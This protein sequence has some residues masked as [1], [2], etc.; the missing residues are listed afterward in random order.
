MSSSLDGVLGLSLTNGAVVTTINNSSGTTLFSSTSGDINITAATGF[1][2]NLS[3]TAVTGPMSLNGTVGTA[4]QVPV[5]QGPGLPVI[6]GVGGGTVTSVGLAMPSIFTVSNSPVVGAGTLT[7]ALNTQADNLVF[8]GPITGGP[9]APTFRALDSSDITTAMLTPPAIGTTTPA[10][11]KFTTLTVTGGI[12][13]PVE[14]VNVVFAGPASG[15]AAAPTFRAL[16]ATDINTP[17]ATS[18]MTPPSI[19]GTTPNAAIFTDAALTTGSV[20]SAPVAA[21]D[22]ANKAYVDLYIQGLTS[23]TTVKAATTTN[24]TLTG[25]QVIDTVPVVAGDIVLV[26]DQGSPAANGVYTVVAG[27]WT[28]APE[29]DVWS[30]FHGAFV[31]VETIAGASNSATGWVCTAPL[32][33]TIDV[34]P[35]PFQQFS[36]AGTY[37]AGTG[38]TLT[39]S[40]FSAN[41]TNYPLAVSANSTLAALLTAN[42][43][44]DIKGNTYS[45]FN[46]TASTVTITTSINNAISYP[47]N[48]TAVSII[49]QAGETVL[50]ETVS[51]NVLYAVTSSSYV[52]T[53]PVNIIDDVTTNIAEYL[54]FSRVTSGDATSLYVASSDISYN[55]FLN[56]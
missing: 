13:F 30:Q 7:A 21:N 18:M 40:V 52:E 23:Q 54:T 14:N 24:I 50:V 32:A 15:A 53:A 9:L 45:L 16:A 2:V 3:N 28:R 49:V 41:E 12:T 43:V 26:K 38:L 20:T 19:G 42:A 34:T 39:G 46:T 44:T 5:S 55:P 31:F 22:I 10:A 17:L 8:A 51:A 37:T 29:M 6:W 47:F 1:K 27:P 48:A 33:G 11:G 56:Q 35:A 25:L 36:A 4:G